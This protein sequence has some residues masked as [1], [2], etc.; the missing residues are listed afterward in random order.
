MTGTVIGLIIPPGIS[1][2]V[3]TTDPRTSKRRTNSWM[4]TSIEGMHGAAEGTMKYAP[5]RVGCCK[6]T[7]EC[8]CA[9]ME[10]AR[11]S[12]E[13]AC[14]TA[15]RSGPAMKAAHCAPTERTA[16]AVK[17]GAA[18]TV[19]RTTPSAVEPVAALGLR[20]REGECG[21]RRRE[22]PCHHQLIEHLTNSPV[23]VRPFADAT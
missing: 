21:K 19:N 1:V 4:D 18:P 10:R 8:G 7:I 3:T 22:S 16:A 15:E 5:A 11:S 23:V 12:V 13:C 9:A 17:G 6:S 2:V 20:G 14:R